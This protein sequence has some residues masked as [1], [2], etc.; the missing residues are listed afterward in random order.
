[1]DTNIKLNKE[2]NILPVKKYKTFLLFITFII[3]FLIFDLLI[4]EVLRYYDKFD[5]PTQDMHS[6]MWNDFYRSTPNSYDVMFMGSSHARFAFDS[7]LNIKSFNLSSSEQTPLVGYYSL[8]EALKYQKPKLLVYEAYWRL[9][10]IVDN[11]TAAYFAYDYIK[12]IDTKIE[13]LASMYDNKKFPSF[14]LEALCRTY[15]YRDSFF[16]AIKNISNGKVKKKPTS[17]KSV[18]YS[19]FTY[20]QNGYFESDKFVCDEKLFKTNPF[21]NVGSDFSWDKTQDYYFKKTLELCNENN[22]KVL[23]VT[24]PLPKPTM[25]YVK[26]YEKY[27]NQITS[28]TNKFGFEYIDYNKQE[29]AFK[30]EFFYDSNHLNFKGTEALD[31]SLMP[32]I[33]RYLEK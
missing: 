2:P 25:D 16:P 31:N 24:A 27:N 26:N 19:Y 15:K 9:F 21:R 12:G 6:L 1:M 13:F 4:G 33:K 14:L 30:N 7:K 5:T 3:F 28:I 17:S 18:K 10:S 22:I 23:V 29:T 32:I 11:T 20:Y 8:K